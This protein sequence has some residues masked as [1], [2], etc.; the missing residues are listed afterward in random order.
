MSAPVLSVNEI[1]NFARDVNADS[2][3]YLE[4]K[5][6]GK[7]PIDEILKYKAYLIAIQLPIEM[8]IIP[9]NLDHYTVDVRSLITSEGMG[10]R[11]KI[12]EIEILPHYKEDLHMEYKYE[13]KEI[14]SS[15]SF[16]IM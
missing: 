8:D 11:L 16:G 10:C 1:M 13:V 4:R 7:T 2:G 3:K 14:I 12:E 9:D 5:L 15:G 6:D